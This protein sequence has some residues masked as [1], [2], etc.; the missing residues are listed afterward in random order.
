MEQAPCPCSYCVSHTDVF[1]TPAS[2]SLGSNPAPCW[3]L[4]RAPRRETEGAGGGRRAWQ[5]PAGSS[6]FVAFVNPGQ[7][8]PRSPDSIPSFRVESGL[9]S[10]GDTWPP[11]S[12]WQEVS[13]GRG[14]WAPVWV[15][16]HAAA[17][18]CPSQLA[19]LQPL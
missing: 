11:A 9:T 4:P 16:S 14:L 17:G 15:F 5:L 2:P 12:S 3:A 19:G 6:S 10:A 1:L 13:S 8:A 18:Q 7:R